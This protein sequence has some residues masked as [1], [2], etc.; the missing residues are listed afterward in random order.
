MSSRR[1]APVKIQ[2]PGAP[3]T[4]PVQNAPLQKLLICAPSNAAVDEVTKRLIEGVY[5]PDGQRLTPKVVRVGAESQINA[6][7]KEISLDTLVD[8]RMGAEMGVSGEDKATKVKA[9]RDEIETLRALRQRKAEELQST[10]DNS[11]RIAS[12]E[13]EVNTINNKRIILSQQL[14]R[15]RDEIKSQNRTNDAIRR[16]Y[17]QEILSGADVICSTL[18]GAG[19]EQLASFDFSMVIIDEAS[20]SVELSSLIPLKYQCKRCV[21]VGGENIMLRHIIHLLRQNALD[22]QQLPPTVL[23]QEASKWGYN[24]SL[25]VRLQKHR[26]EAVHLLR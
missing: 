3:S 21:M 10:L 15:L 13:N 26:P 1:S 22:P 16:K 11:S 18:S 5:G 7:V 24:Q 25:F 17:R 2:V 20:Q 8:T 12:L 14:D 19:H 23:S 6:S 9:L 4:K